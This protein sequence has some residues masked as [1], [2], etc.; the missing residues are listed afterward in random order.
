METE[1]PFDEEMRHKADDLD[2][3]VVENKSDGVKDQEKDVE[4]KLKLL[5]EKEENIKMEI[6]KLNLLKQETISEKENVLVLTDE[7][8]KMS[9]EISQK[10][11][12]IDDENKKLKVKRELLLKEEEDL[13]QAWKVFKI[14][15]EA[16]DLKREAFNNINY[17]RQMD[18]LS[19]KKG[20]FVK[21]KQVV[22]DIDELV[23]LSEIFKDQLGRFAEQR[24]HF[25][26]FVEGLKGCK[27]CGYIASDYV[28]S[29]ELLEKVSCYAT[30]VGRSPTEHTDFMS[31]QLSD[32]PVSWLQK[33]S[34][35]IFNFSPKTT[36]H[37]SELGLAD[38]KNCQDEDTS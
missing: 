17:Q 7:L 21:E 33:C 22:A 18:F 4:A 28:L 32:G 16:L 6:E 27:M 9:A 2:Q 14:E 19:S 36:K 11:Q 38:K 15:W 3:K 25:H 26:K 1:K 20:T 10:E 24:V 23:M 35:R 37:L 13:K 5:K 31:S 8:E 12:Q 30:N 34:S 29:D